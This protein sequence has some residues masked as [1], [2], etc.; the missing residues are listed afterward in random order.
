MYMFFNNY[1]LGILFSIGSWLENDNVLVLRHKNKYF[2]EQINK[3]YSYNIY[4]Q[5]VKD[6][7]QYV[8]KIYNFNIQNLYKIGWNNRNSN[9]RDIPQLDCYKDFLRAYLELH[10]CLDYS[11]RYR[12]RGKRDKYKALR[13]RVYGNY[14]II[15]KLNYIISCE[16]SVNVKTVQGLGSSDNGKTSYLAYCDFVEIKNI[17]NYVFDYPYCE[18]YWDDVEGKMSKP[19]LFG[20]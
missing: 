17:Y 8:L 1:E 12:Y 14:N 9:I 10:G 13:L 11:V 3:Y 18:E 4:K 5:C 15:Y 19:V 16:C 7:N 6:K 20:E 2:L